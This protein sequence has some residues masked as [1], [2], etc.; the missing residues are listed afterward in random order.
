MSIPEQ[1]KEQQRIKNAGKLLLICSL[2]LASLWGGGAWYRS[3][4]HDWDYCVRNN[5]CFVCHAPAVA[6]EGTY[7]GL[8]KNV[9]LCPEHSTGPQAWRS[10]V[11]GV[12]AAMLIY[13]D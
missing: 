6:A 13:E 7:K 8:G 5:K 2:L 3:T 11:Y 12:P 1:S 9:R 10:V 4:I